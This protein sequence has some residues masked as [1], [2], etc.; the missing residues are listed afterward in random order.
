MSSGAGFLGL[1]LASWALLSSTTHTAVF[2]SF[3]IWLLGACA[4]IMM[5]LTESLGGIVSFKSG[6]NPVRLPS[7]LSKWETE[8]QTDQVIRR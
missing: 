2:L 4:K 5:I 3:A 7:P 8:A 1:K 6:D